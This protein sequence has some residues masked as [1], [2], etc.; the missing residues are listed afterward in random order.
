MEEIKGFVITLVSIIILISAIELISPDNSMKKYLKFVLGTILISVM[1]SPIVSILSNGE[2]ILTYKIS[3][4][5]DLEENNSLKTSNE[6][7]ETTS[8]ALFKEN[9]EENFNKILK[10]KFKEYEFE[11]YVDCEVNIQ[12]ITYTINEISIGV[13]SKEISKIE[14][15]VINNENESSEVNTSQEKLTNEDEIKD[16]LVEVL[17]ITKDKIKIYRIK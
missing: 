7:N 9:L 15:V 4:Y 13:K 1:I 16:Y 8:E 10:E 14:K 12:D 3:E 5:T 6:N 11:T 2:N 17:E